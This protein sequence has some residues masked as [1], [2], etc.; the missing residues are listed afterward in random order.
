[1][2]S[3]PPELVRVPTI[4]DLVRR[5]LATSLG[6]DKQGATTIARVSPEGHRVM[7]ESM[8]EN[9]RRMRAHDEVT[10]KPV[11][12]AP[13]DPII[14]DADDPWSDVGSREPV[15]LD[16]ARRIGEISAGLTSP[17]VKQ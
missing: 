4:E 10:K 2:S 15:P 3:D 8:L 5:G 13:V 16:D 9:G 17:D 6:R 14:L 11:S 7:G 12:V 1:M